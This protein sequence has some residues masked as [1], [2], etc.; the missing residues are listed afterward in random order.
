MQI[1]LAVQRAARGDRG[2][3]QRS[4]QDPGADPAGERDGHEAQEAAGAR[5]GGAGGTQGGTWLTD[6]DD[7][8][9]VLEERKTLR[10][11]L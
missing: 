3:A 2:H 6:D 7:E 4:D 9:V 11:W 1:H 10:G 8:M 5:D